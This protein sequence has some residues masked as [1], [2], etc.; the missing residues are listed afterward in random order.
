MSRVLTVGTFDLYHSGHVNFLR[1]CAKI[2]GLF[3]RDNYG[4]IELGSP[5]K[6]NQ[7]TVGLNSDE[8]VERYKGKKPLYSFEERYL[9]LGSSQYVYNVVKNDQPDGTIQDLFKWIKPDILVI[10]S[11]WAQKDYYAQIGVTQEWLDQNNITL[12]YVPYTQGVSTTQLKERI[13]GT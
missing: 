8:F 13:I 4:L 11:D 1:Q 6:Y 10:G 9:L 2:A 7:V 5:T 12:C 3:K